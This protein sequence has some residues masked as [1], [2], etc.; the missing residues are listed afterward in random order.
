M[1]YT[2]KLPPWDLPF[3]RKAA[4]LTHWGRD[5]MASISQTTLSNVFSWMKML[6]FLLKFHRSLFL[7]VQLTIFQHWFMQW[8]GTDQVTSHYMNQWWLDYRCIY[9]LLGLNELNR[10]HIKIMCITWSQGMLLLVCLLIWI[11]IS[12]Q[13]LL[14]VCSQYFEMYFLHW[15]FDYNFAE[16]WIG[17]SSHDKWTSCSQITDACTCHPP[18]THW[19]QDKMLAVFQMKFSNAFP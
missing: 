1:N 13:R 18:L 11:V 9:A 8:L 2:K 12:T 6:E 16:I 17:S 5:K 15:V 3:P 14:I 4:A 10:S 19:G 7:R